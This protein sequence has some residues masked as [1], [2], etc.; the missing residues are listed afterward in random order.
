[1]EPVFELDVTHPERGS[2]SASEHIY[3]Q[4]HDAIMEGR[5]AA[6]TRMP[7]TR[8]SK[9]VFGVSRNVLSGVYARLMLDGLLT[10]RPG[11]GTYVAARRSAHAP[12]PPGRPPFALNRYWS[13]PESDR[14]VN[15][16]RP[17]RGE[18]IDGPVIADFRPAVVDPAL[19]PHA[20]FRRIM[21]RQLRRSECRPP[22]MRSPQ[23][24]QGNFRFRTAI[25][26]HVSLTRAIHCDPEEIL[27]TQGAQQAFDILARSLVTPGETLVA[28]E[29]PGYPPM[30]AAFAAA[31]ARLAPVGVDHGGMIVGAIPPQARIICLTPSHQF[32]LGMTMPPARREA[33]IAAARSRGA[34]V[35]E[36]DYDGEFRLHGAPAG[37]LRSADT[38]DVVFHVGTF[39]KCMLPAYRAGY[40]VAPRWAVPTLTRVRNAIDWHSP[41][42]MQAAIAAFMEE[43]GL[44]RHIR[45]MRSVYNRRRSQLG[46]ILKDQEDRGLIL[47]ESRY[48]MH[49]SVEF[50]F[51]IDVDE[52]ESSLLRHG[53]HAH[54]LS[55]YFAG[56]PTRSG[57]VFG[58]GATDGDQIS[59]GLEIL[60]SCMRQGRG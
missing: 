8:Y 27:V 31:G 40:L 26:R 33:L 24:N 35:V 9:A 2:R 56:E 53:V 44:I 3:R 15:F 58:I 4:L 55:R 36:D 49:M 48:G 51:R 32:P 19:F 7:P 14:A 21:A 38:A 16:W 17:P 23:G 10:G 18:R 5:L 28:I 12:G 13:G 22:K 41:A 25:A 1:M 50:A 11:S 42:P 43:G 6:R 34:V 46:A 29:D 39:S 60:V 30:R 57:L 45:Q 52:L 37:T 47:N 59:R 20:A 54:S